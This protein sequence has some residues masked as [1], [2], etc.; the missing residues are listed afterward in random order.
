MGR[1]G[2]VRG[3]RGPSAMI[4][5]HQMAAAIAMKAWKAR[6]VVRL[7]AAGRGARSVLI[8]GQ[9]IGGWMLRLGRV[10]IDIQNWVW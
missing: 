7:G 10:K 3:R 6:Y 5:A 9:G 4:T 2:T 8:V 1:D